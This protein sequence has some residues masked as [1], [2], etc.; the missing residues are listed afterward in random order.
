MPSGLVLKLRWGSIAKIQVRFFLIVKRTSNSS[1]GSISEMPLSKDSQPL[2]W[3]EIWKPLKSLRN[4][5]ETHYCWSGK[6]RRQ[7]HQWDG[8]WQFWTYLCLALNCLFLAA[9]K[10]EIL[11]VKTGIEISPLFARHFMNAIMILEKVSHSSRQSM[12]GIYNTG[13]L[14]FLQNLPDDHKLHSGHQLHWW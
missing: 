1:K 12:K 4:E 7:Y 14:F 5:A 6:S 11:G 10:H 3:Y 2:L 13:G 9:R 8:A